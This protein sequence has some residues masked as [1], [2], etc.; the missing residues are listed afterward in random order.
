MKK[1]EL[2]TKEEIESYGFI[3]EPDI[4]KCKTG[5]IKSQYSTS[6]FQFNKLTH[7]KTVFELVPE[8]EAKEEIVF[9]IPYTH[10]HS[11]HV[12]IPEEEKD[13]LF[14]HVHNKIWYTGHTRK[15]D[16]TDEEV[17]NFLNRKK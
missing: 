12:N 16:P 13:I 4:N 7:S 6:T 1:I 15:P 9:Q 2:F 14:G 5:R 3:Y 17:E 8:K 10:I 11:I